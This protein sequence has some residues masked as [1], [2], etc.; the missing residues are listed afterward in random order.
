M[1]QVGKL[2]MSRCSCGGGIIVVFPTAHSIEQAVRRH[3]QI[4]L[5]R[6]W[7]EAVRPEWQGT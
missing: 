2:S 5:H 3:Q 6:E 4:R 7:W 1:V